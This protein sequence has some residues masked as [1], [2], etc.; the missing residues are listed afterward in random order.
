[1]SNNCG[2]CAQSLRTDTFKVKCNGFCKKLFHGK[3]CLNLSDYNINQINENV[4]INYIC[5]GCLSNFELLKNNYDN[6]MSALDIN[7]VSIIEKVDENL[8]KVVEKIKKLKQ[9]IISEIKEKNNCDEKN[10]RPMSYADKL[11]LPL[12]VKPRE[13]QQNSSKTIEEIKNKINPSALSVNVNNIQELKNNGAI[14]ISCANKQ[15]VEKIEKE[16][17]DKFGENYEVQVPYLHNPK[18]LVVGMSESLSPDEIIDAIKTQNV[19]EIK[20]IKCHK[21]FKS[22]KNNAIFNAIVEIDGGAFK[23]IIDEGKI[24]IKWDRCRAYEMVSVLRCFKCLGFNHK[25]DKCTIGACCYKCGEKDHL[26]NECNVNTIKCLNCSRAKDQLGLRSIDVKH[27]TR[28]VE[29]P[30]YK[31]KLSI[32]KNKIIY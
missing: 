15:S 29:C 11:K 4:N 24:N 12:I 17:K 20:N 18:M 8:N 23:K 16:I 31:K 6:I 25:A 30:L 9:E 3:K 19:L 14:S 26:A 21:V 5:D 1:M 28:S 10:K 13:K 7:K 22:K 27:D 2:K 32:E